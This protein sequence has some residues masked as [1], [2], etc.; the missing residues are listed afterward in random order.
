LTTAGLAAF[1]LL[2]PFA[3]TGAAAFA[4]FAITDYFY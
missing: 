4:F 2:F 1:T 3:G